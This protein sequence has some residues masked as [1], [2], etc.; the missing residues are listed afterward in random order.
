MKSKK[1]IMTLSA[2]FI[3][4]FHLWINI[5]NSTTEVFLRNLCVV[6]VDLFFF[7]STYSISK[8][9]NI[10]YKEFVFNRFNNIYFKFIVLSI[11]CSLYSS[12]SLTKFLKTITGLSLF[13]SGGGSFLWF[14]PG[15]MIIYLLIPIYKKLDDKRPIIVPIC[16]ISIYLLF[17]ILVSLF[18][19]YKEIFILTNRIPIMLLGYYIGK[20]NVIEYLNKNRFKYFII[21]I[22]LLIIGLFISYVTI[23]HRIKVEWLYDIYYI[24]NIPIELALILIL[25]K[26]KDNKITNLLGSCTLELYGIQMIFG[27][28]LVNKIYLLTKNPILCNICTI[29]LFFI[30][31]ILLK[32][33]FDLKDK[34]LNLM[35][36]KK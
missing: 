9:N 34:F 13:I 10:N 31:A 35:K 11:I 20:H 28:T 15:I 33:I 29:I 16:M 4:I 19:N 26:T 2:L 3:L 25:A 5:T 18:T 30:L 1:T 17:S 21:S 23:I 14:L 6:G 7:V 36:S 22:L 24:L 12:W 32:Y 27:Y 8:K